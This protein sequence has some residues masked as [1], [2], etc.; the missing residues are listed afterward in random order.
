MPSN[1][2]CT[3]DPQWQLPADVC[4]CCWF[5]SFVFFFHVF[6]SPRWRLIRI[7]AMVRHLQLNLIGSKNMQHLNINNSQA[8][9]FPPFFSHSYSGDWISTEMS[10]SFRIVFFFLIVINTFL[11]ATY[12]ANRKSH[13]TLW[14]NPVQRLNAHHMLHDSLSQ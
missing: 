1:F 10:A 11:S 7:S 5:H 4:L 12:C 9:R 8:Q 14:E 13:A 3:C 2:G 6:S